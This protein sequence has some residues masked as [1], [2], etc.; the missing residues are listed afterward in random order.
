MPYC[1]GCCGKDGLD[2]PN[3]VR[4]LRSGRGQGQGRLLDAA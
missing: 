3:V 4:A 1:N 2:R